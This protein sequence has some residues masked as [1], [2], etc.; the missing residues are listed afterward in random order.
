MASAKLREVAPAPGGLKEEISDFERRRIREEACHQFNNLSSILR[1][2]PS[3][4]L[5]YRALLSP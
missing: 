2:I 4:R 1:R 3:T 5:L